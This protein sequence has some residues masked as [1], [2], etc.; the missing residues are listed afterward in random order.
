[1][2]GKIKK[3][4]VIK[5]FATNLFCFLNKIQFFKIGHI[6]GSFYYGYIATNVNAGKFH[7]KPSTS[8]QN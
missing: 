3:S 4:D 5:T 6:L 2:Q 1:M 7:L 8:D